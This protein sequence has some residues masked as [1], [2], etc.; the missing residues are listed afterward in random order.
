MPHT[1]KVSQKIRE[2]LDKLTNRYGVAD[3][4]PL[5]IEKAVYVFD[6][7]VDEKI[8]KKKSAKEISPVTVGGSS[9]SGGSAASAGSP[10]SSPADPQ[11]QPEA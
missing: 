11:G 7:H 3:L 4:T 5:R 6:F 2:Y 10:P 8:S 1:S 9:S